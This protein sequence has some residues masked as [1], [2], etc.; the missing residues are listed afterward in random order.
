M[1]PFKVLGASPSG[2]RLKK[3]QQSA[4]Y[5]G[6]S[7]RNLNPTEITLHGASMV[8][9]AKDFFNRPK[10]TAPD[11]VLPSVATDLKSLN[12]D[13]PTV[14]WFGH[15]SYLIRYRGTTILVDPVMN[16]HASPFPFLVKSFAGSDV[17][18]VQD[19]PPIDMM[20]LTHDHYDHLDYS[21]IRQ[22]AP[23]TK[24]FYTSLGVGAHLEY[25][26]VSPAAIKEFDWWEELRL[27]DNMSL[28]AAP[29]R[30]FS[31]RTLKR[32]QTLWSSFIL[33]LDDYTL[34]LGGD[35][36]YD[37]HFA[38][39]GKR[40]DGFDLAILEIG[41]YGRNWPYIHT[42]P[43]ETVQ[44]AVDLRAK[45]LLPVHW[46]KFTLALHEWDEPIRRLVVAARRQ[47]MSITTPMIGEPVVI[48]TSYPVAEWWDR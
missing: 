34:F 22:L 1:F 30:H 39:I 8:K 32:N 38:E 26:G 31:G 19:M 41:Q 35:S 11:S 48:D 44:A 25:W 5:K 14:V 47:E 20:I 13:A 43:E 40:Y 33:K 36:G 23:R 42:L 28:T 24:M 2:E 3:I 15:S 10:N 17:Y 18:S 46:G 7:F 16:G 4:Q 45:M 29:A 9:M 37:T 21:T 6:G 27:A 12:F